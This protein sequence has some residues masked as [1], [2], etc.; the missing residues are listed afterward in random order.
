MEK[1]YK[2]I[3]VIVILVITIL[4]L[5]QVSSKQINE[6]IINEVND[7]SNLSLRET[8]FC[9]V[10]YISIFYNYTVRNDEL[11]TLEDI[12]LNGGDCFEYSKLYEKFGKSLG[13]NAYTFIIKI[14]DGKGHMFAILA[15]DMGFC[16]INLI[17]EPYC[18]FYQK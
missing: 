13:F 9:L 18:L 1:I 7:C 3:L 11:K 10:D 15:N 12:K 4:F 14:E 2:T 6:E 16:Q 5:S 8:A 17:E